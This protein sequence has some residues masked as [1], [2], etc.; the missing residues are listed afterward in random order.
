[1]FP[2]FTTGLIMTTDQHD[3]FIKFLKLKP[4]VF[5]GTKS[6]DAY[7]FLVDC[8]ELLHK[9]D[10]VERFSVEFVTY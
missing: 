2:R 4:P 10:I 9:M 7:D 1:M 8:H 6:E 5:K 3:L